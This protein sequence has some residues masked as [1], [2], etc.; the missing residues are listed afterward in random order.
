VHAMLAAVGLSVALHGVPASP[1]SAAIMA[2]V[3]Q[4]VDAF[5]Q[6][7]TT[8]AVAACAK[9][10]SV[11]DE[12]PPYT[13]RGDGGCA[14]WLRDYD[15]DARKNGITDGVVTLAAPR[16]VD[17]S[18]DHAYVVIPADY[19]FKARGKAV[20]ETHSILTV[21]LRKGAAGWRIT[22]WSWAKN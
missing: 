15:A 2:V 9:K 20:K 1:D 18:A 3:H 13:W 19:A 6:G 21:V 22:A 8:A 5:N 10:A 12:F 7:D 14:E 16:H 11:I 17:I 4:F